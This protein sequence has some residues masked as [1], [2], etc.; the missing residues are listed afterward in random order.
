MET[1][2]GLG[3]GTSVSNMEQMMANRMTPSQD[4][5]YGAYLQKLKFL[6]EKAK[7]DIQLARELKRTKMTYD[8]FEDTPQFERIFNDYQ[9]RLMNIV[10][11]SLGAPAKKTAPAGNITADDLKKQLGK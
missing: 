4:D 9:N 8:E 11:P 5:P 10:S 2:K 6:Q 3:A 7:F 1:R